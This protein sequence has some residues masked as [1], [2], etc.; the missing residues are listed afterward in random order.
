MDNTHLFKRIRIKNRGQI[1]GKTGVFRLCTGRAIS[2]GA[3]DGLAGAAGQMRGDVA[4]ERWSRG[5]R[6]SIFRLLTGPQRRAAWRLAARW[7]LVEVEMFE[8][9]VQG[10]WWTAYPAILALTCRHGGWMLVGVGGCCEV[11]EPAA[12]RDVLFPM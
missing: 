3:V 1:V 11:V 9:F 8:P 10:N 6:P 4:V 2:T 7:S 5:G 12:P